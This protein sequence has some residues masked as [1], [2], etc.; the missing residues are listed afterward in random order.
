ML[1]KWWLICALWM[2]ASSASAQVHEGAFKLSLETELL[3][4]QK[5]VQKYGGDEHT[6]TDVAVGPSS[7]LL[8]ATLPSLVSFGVGYVANPHVIPQLSFSFGHR[9]SS[10]KIRVQEFPEENEERH[11][12]AGVIMVQPRLEFPF[13]PKSKFVVSALAGFDYRRFKVK[14]ADTYTLHGFGPVVGLVGHIFITDTVSLDLTPLV[15]IDFLKSKVEPGYSERA[16]EPDT[17][18]QR[19]FGVLIGLSAWPGH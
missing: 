18:R 12:K 1:R 2:V 7:M 10:E 6:Y 14:D 15:Q 16:S 9:K 13:N 17:Y 3:S 5:L 11:L 19:M 4:Y 8:G